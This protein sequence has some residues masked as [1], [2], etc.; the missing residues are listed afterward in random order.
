MGSN[1]HMDI[2]RCFEI[3]EL[4]RKASP[5][6]ARLAYKDLVAI[7]HPD[8]F[9]G[10]PRLRQKA[11]EKLKEINRAYEGVKAYFVAEE[12]QEVGRKRMSD[13][14]RERTKREGSTTRRG[15][16]RT[17]EV[18]EVGTR[19][20]LYAWYYL[21][22]ALRRLS[23]HLEKGKGAPGQGG[24]DASGGQGQGEKGGRGNVAEG[25]S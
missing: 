4:D 5:E 2:K 21:S 14:G 8:R 1:G 11:E 10:N 17:E 18:A 23:T 3:L 15:Q 22:K 12:A 13:P 19:M 16:G 7:W 9:A 20:A 25:G 24:M 6:Q